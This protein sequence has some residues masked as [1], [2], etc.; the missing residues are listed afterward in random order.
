M[1]L[2]LVKYL[3]NIFKL[4]I[5]QTWHSDF[6]TTEVNCFSNFTS[7]CNHDNPLERTFS[8]QLRLIF[9]WLMKQ[10]DMKN[11]LYYMYN[12]LC[13]LLVIM[14]NSYFFF[15]ISLF[16]HF[17]KGGKTG[18]RWPRGLNWSRRRRDSH[19]GRGLLLSSPLPWLL[20]PLIR[21]SYYGKII[22]K[23]KL[24]LN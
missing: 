23:Q 2:T 5:F 7:K 10:H 6:S 3:S 12:N 9:Q 17:K 15:K 18:G 16:L 14:K 1:T 22:W 21:I 11:M 13:C 8:N 24:C 20:L 4:W 19:C